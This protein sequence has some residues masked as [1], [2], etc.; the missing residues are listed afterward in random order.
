MYKYWTPM[1]VKITVLPYQ[2]YW[3]INTNN[4]SQL[5]A[6]PAYTCNDLDL[7][8]GQSDFLN[9]MAAKGVKPFSSHPSLKEFSKS[10]D[11]L[12]RLAL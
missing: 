8:M 5:T 6:R 9:K 4:T 1:R 3:S 2:P 12:N 11:K 10:Y 7:T